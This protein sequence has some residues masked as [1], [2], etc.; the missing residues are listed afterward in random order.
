VNSSRRE[1]FSYVF[2]EAML[3]S[4]PVI[5]TNVPIAN[6][7]LPEHHIYRG[8]S[9]DGF[10]KLFNSD[11]G[12]MFNDQTAARKRAQQELTLDSMINNTLMVYHACNA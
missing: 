7:F 3:A 6:E 4:K 10:A 5:S 12:V 9:P 11:L 2:A 1:G 8:E